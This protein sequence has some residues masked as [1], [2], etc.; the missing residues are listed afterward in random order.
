MKG[1]LS[2][3]LVVVQGVGASVSAAKFAVAMAEAYGTSVTAV[4]AVDTAAIR[5]L[6]LS[7]IFVDDEGEEYERSLELTGKRHLAY[8]EELARSRGVQ[9]R[10]LLL[11]G[12]IAEEV[13]RTAEETDADCIVL[14]GWE[15]GG[16]FRDILLEANREIARMAR[17][18]VIIVKGRDAGD[19][20]DALAA[21]IAANAREGHGTE[22]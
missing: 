20:G 21:H 2:R 10:T 18:P 19:A 5:R 4:Y 8:V 16:D 3:A 6:S 9:A 14:A 17:C 12:S 15:R 13:V 11:K 7:R 1:P 22:G